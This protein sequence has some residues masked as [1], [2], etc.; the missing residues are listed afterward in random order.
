MPM[1]TFAPVGRPLEPVEVGGG[2]EEVDVAGVDDE[3]VEEERVLELEIEEELEEL[4]ELDELDLPVDEDE[5][6]NCA[7]TAVGEV[8]PV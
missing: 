4:E 5:M 3:V 2:T 6:L 8:A 7:D 1:P